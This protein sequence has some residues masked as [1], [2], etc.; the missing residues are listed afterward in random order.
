MSNI[1]TP[2]QEKSVGFPSR[3]VGRK[4]RF[5]AGTSLEQVRG[6]LTH[7]GNDYLRQD[8]SWSLLRHLP[9]S[10]Q[11]LAA[12]KS[13]VNRQHYPSESPSVTRGNASSGRSGS[14]VLR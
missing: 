10:Y 13:C 9:S 11:R 1:Q 2:A 4:A 12:S 6:A 7:E 3:A 5:V 8:R 14:G